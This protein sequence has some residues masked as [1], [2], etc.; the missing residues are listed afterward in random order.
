MRTHTHVCVQTPSSRAAIQCDNTKPW[1]CLKQ[2]LLSMF[3][4]QLEVIKQN[5]KRDQI[6]VGSFR[7]AMYK[8]MMQERK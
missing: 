1:Y 8:E 2:T 5:S 3:Q 6:R 4:K 7:G